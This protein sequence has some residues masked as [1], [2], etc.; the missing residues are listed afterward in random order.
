MQGRDDEFGGGER[1]QVV[2]EG[3]GPW[4][5]RG[6]EV[7]CRSGH[8]AD[9]GAEAEKGRGSYDCGLFWGGGGVS[10]VLV[11]LIEWSDV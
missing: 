10:G 8:C 1:F 4:R 5:A 2:L 9:E 11:S 3:G 6:G 7:G